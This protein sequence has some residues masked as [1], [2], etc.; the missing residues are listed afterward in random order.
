MYEKGGLNPPC[1]NVPRGTLSN[2]EYYEIFVKV[3]EI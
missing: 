1:S 2:K 3:I